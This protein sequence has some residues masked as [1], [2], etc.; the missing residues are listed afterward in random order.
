MTVSFRSAGSGRPVGRVS[1]PRSGGS[2]GGLGA[3]RDPRDPGPVPAGYLPLALGLV[4]DLS[5]LPFDVYLVVGGHPVLYA[6]RDADPLSLVARVDRAS[7]PELVVRSGD[8]AALRATLLE[9]LTLA[10]EGGGERGAVGDHSRRIAGLTA[11]LLEPVLGGR[12]HA[13]SM[14][15]GGDPPGV[16][17]AGSAALLVAAEAARLAGGA[18]VA[19]PR[20]AGQ[21]LG[22]RP[23]PTANRRVAGIGAG[24]V[25][26]ERAIDGIA[27]ASAMA[28]ILGIDPLVAAEAVALRDVA[29]PV[30]TGALAASPEHRRHPLVAADRVLAAGGSVMV[31]SAIAAHH[32]R[33]DGSG[34]PAGLR[35]GELGPTERLVALIDILVTMTHRDAVGGLPIGEAFRALRMAVAGRF[36]G[37]MVFAI[38]GLIADGTLGS[39]SGDRA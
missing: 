23:A 37:R 30:G 17:S 27:L 25:N 20:L 4:A 5:G 36:D 7:C 8:G 31:A 14:P 12:I 38:A 11:A 6:R 15:V 28:R 26:V 24:L 34:H 9:S 39:G 1:A 2:S 29:L 33:L 32:E 10:V 13:G 35:G 19:R 18:V 22:R 21:I 3:G 16:R